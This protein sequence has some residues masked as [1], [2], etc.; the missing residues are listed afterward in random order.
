MRSFQED[1]KGKYVGVGM[2]I[3]K[4]VGEP[5]TVVS[6]I[7]DG[8]AYKAGIKPKRSNCGNRWR[9]QHIT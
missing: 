9:I 3:Q 8:P 2:V 5:L 6:P 7:E 1:I 4:K